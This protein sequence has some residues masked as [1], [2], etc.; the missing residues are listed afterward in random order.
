MPAAILSLQQNNWWW[1]NPSPQVSNISW[2]SYRY[3]L[4][5]NLKCKIS[6]S[7]VNTGI[8]V[9]NRVLQT[10]PNWNWFFS[11][12]RKVLN[13][14]FW[15]SCWLTGMSYKEGNPLKSYLFKNIRFNKSV[16]CVDPYWIEAWIPNPLYK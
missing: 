16:W 3:A 10:Y 4:I 13:N 6:R 1:I 5:H 7:W 11:L 8:W 12:P 14:G 2:T 15:I 9:K